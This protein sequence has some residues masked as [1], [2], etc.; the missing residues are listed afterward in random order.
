MRDRGIR[1]AAALAIVTAASGC[2]L[3]LGIDGEYTEGVTGLCVSVSDC[4]DKKGDCQAVACTDGE[5]SAAPNEMDIDDGNDCTM[6]SCSGGQ[7]QHAP[8]SVGASCSTDDGHVCDGAGACV[9]CNGASDCES[10]ICV[11][12]TCATPTCDDG[13]KNGTESDVDCGGACPSKC[14]NGQGCLKDSDCKGGYCSPGSE[15]C[16]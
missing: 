1:R 6:D 15:M 4:P 12:S 5:C 2:S 8:L 11:Q 14:E 10:A 9:E 3:L 16:E 13:V 7:S